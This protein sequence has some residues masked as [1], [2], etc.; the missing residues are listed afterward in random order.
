MTPAPNYEYFLPGI[1]R[2]DFELN[3]CDCTMVD[4]FI[5]LRV[6]LGPEAY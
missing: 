1:L 3:S 2:K 6:R 5:F 4:S